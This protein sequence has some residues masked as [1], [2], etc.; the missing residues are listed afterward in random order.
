MN[1]K[2]ASW[3]SGACAVVLG[4][5][6]L[7]SAGAQTMDTLGTANLSRAVMADGQSLPAGTYTLQLSSAEVDSV[8]GVPDGSEQ[9]V[10]FVQGGEVR[11]RELASRVEAADVS[12]I[13]ETNPP[14][15]GTVRVEWLRGGEYLRVW[16][17]HAGTHYLLHL[18]AG[19]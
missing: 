16:T 17:N 6:M 13:A 2:S 3:W 18:A 1:T 10:E 14:S 15:P 7:A 11:G 5:G 12:E 8:V 4:V 19:Q 9:W